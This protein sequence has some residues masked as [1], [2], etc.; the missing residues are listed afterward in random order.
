VNNVEQGV[1]ALSNSRESTTRPDSTRP[2]GCIPRPIG[3]RCILHRVIQQ[4]HQLADGNDKPVS[5]S[6]LVATS[7]A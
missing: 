5:E 3:A 7:F 6:R 4:L 2:I 1:A